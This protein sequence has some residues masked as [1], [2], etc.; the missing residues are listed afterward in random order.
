M[1]KTDNI[2]AIAS[3]PGLGAIS[4]I[5][6]SGNDCINQIDNIFYGFDKI[7]LIDQQ[8][9][10]LQLDILRMEIRSLIRF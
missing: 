7:K 2:V 9:H 10:K 5:R 6:I 4:L 8:S 3:P 1:I